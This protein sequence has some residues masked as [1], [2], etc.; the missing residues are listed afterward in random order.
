MRIRSLH[1]LT[2][3]ISLTLI[4]AACSLPSPARPATS[5]PAAAYTAA[6]E[7][8]MAEITQ[9]AQTQAPTSAGLPP[10]QPTTPPFGATATGSMTDTPSPTETPTPT[11]TPVQSSSPTPS[12]APEDPRAGLGDPDF[13]DTFEN[14]TNWSLYTDDHVSFEID[15]D[16]LVMTAFDP[17]NW[18]G[19]TVSWP[20]IKDF[21]LEMTTN[22]GDCS[23][24]DR[25]GLVARATKTGGDY[26]TYAFG[27]TCDGRYSLRIWDGE[28]YVTVFDW[29]AS[30]A[31]HAGS[32][33][34]NRI[35]ILADGNR[36]SLY[37]NGR[38]LVTIQDDSFEQGKFGVFI[39]SAN[40][41]D[42]TVRA[43]EIA[44]W[45]LP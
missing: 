23:G 39:G 42:F 40:T 34:N 32:N 31:I 26:E 14:A 44:Y 20:E 28:R 3:L 30:E 38:K 10:G 36:L 7:T 21:Y 41:P 45:E 12:V 25:H 11:P 8:I 37:A 35:G 6:A 13:F 16:Q 29:A 17:E 2:L 19:W 5:D 43:D 22:T 4:L 1:Q 27:I 18:D 24:M 9:V 33:Q 15:D